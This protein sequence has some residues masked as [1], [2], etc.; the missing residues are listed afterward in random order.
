[1]LDVNESRCDPPLAAGEVE[2]IA[3]S[4]FRRAPCKASP[5]PD[6]ETLEA[7][8]MI[9]RELFRRSWRRMGELSA[10]D[11]YVAL[12]KEARKYGQSIPAGVRVSIGIRP[13]ALSAATSKPTVL[14]AIRRLREAGIIRRDD[15][16]RRDERSGAFVLVTPR[17]NLDHSS[18]AGST[19]DSGQP[20][21]APRLRWPAPG[22]RRLGKSC[23]AL[24]DAL[25]AAG[26]GATVGELAE[27]LNKARPR[28]LRRRVIPRLEEA[29]VVEVS[30]D[31]VSLTA[32]YLDAIGRERERAGEI[33]AFRRDMLRFA[34]ES[35]AYLRRH[36]V[37]PEPVPKRPDPRDI[38]HLAHPD[39]L[40]LEPGDLDA[41]E[42]IRVFEKKYGPGAFRWNQTGCKE[43]FYSG[44]IP[45]FWPE[46]AQLRRIRDYLEAGGAE[47][48]A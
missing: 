9:E 27:M 11:V 40:E 19:G 23:G 24:V 3:R 28:D 17:A 22:I 42:A 10:R 29:A 38:S 41:L 13:L 45:G 25:E 18:T 26:G 8:G 1:L 43:L 14:K 16:G 39:P 12:I 34:L 6:A 15:S 48:A 47:R 7:L 21:R 4:I 35:E 44:P 5:A 20:L 32:D 31:R 33:A 2:K 46:P 37:T 30:G 36:E